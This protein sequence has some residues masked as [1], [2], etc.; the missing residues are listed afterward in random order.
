MREG[1]CH[2]DFSIFP[3][4]GRSRSL[5]N[6]LRSRPREFRISDIDYRCAIPHL[7]FHQIIIIISRKIRTYIHVRRAQSGSVEQ[8]F[9]ILL[10]ARV[11]TLAA[12]DTRTC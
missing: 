9:T 12:R 4:A 10:P 7:A 3:G 8:S 5:S 1:Y 11:S 2:R 6:Y